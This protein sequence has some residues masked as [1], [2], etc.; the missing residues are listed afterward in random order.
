MFLWALIK[1]VSCLG[2]AATLAAIPF[3]RQ[4]KCILIHLVSDLE[5]EFGIANMSI[6][7]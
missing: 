2:V 1:I 6:I 7:V 5:L 4:A 3:D